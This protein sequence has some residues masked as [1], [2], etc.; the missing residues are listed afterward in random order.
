MNIG[1][2]V[3]IKQ[4]SE[5]CTVED[6]GPR[7]IRVRFVWKYNIRSAKKD[8][9]YTT[10][11]HKLVKAKDIVSVLTVDYGDDELIPPRG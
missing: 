6:I 7:Y 11:E 4:T 9:Y 1:S 3:R 10:V 8:D 5:I 2:Q